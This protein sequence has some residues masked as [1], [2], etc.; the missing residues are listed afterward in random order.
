MLN[1]ATPHPAVMPW[2]QYPGRAG[3]ST[4]TLYRWWDTTEA[5]MLDAA[6]EHLR[7]ALTYEGKGS[8]L[9]R[10]RQQA[11]RG[12]KFLRSEDGKVMARL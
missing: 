3:V 9:E 1:T 12:I 5:I 10:L 8:P 2:A 11:V 7:P 6:M 4:A